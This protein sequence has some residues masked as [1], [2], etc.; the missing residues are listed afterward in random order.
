MLSRRLIQKLE[1]LTDDVQAHFE[2]QADLFFAIPHCRRAVALHLVKDD[3]VPTRK[4][5]YSQ[6]VTR[7]MRAVA[8]SHAALQRSRSDLKTTQRHLSATAADVKTTVTTLPK[9]P[10]AKVS[11]VRAR[12]AVR[13]LKVMS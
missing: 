2:T 1:A 12:P 7:T 4:R 8:A 11:S 13:R 9:P 10:A 6:A 3:S 5:N